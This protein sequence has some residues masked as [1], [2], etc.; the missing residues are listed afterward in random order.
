MM[1]VLGGARYITCIHHLLH[2]I[3]VL[4]LLIAVRPLVVFHHH[5]HHLTHFLH[6]HGIRSRSPVALADPRTP[7]DGDG[8]EADNRTD[9]EESD[10]PCLHLCRCEG[11]DREH[12]QKEDTCEEGDDRQ[13]VETSERNEAEIP[14]GGGHHGFH[15]GIGEGGREKDQ[16][17]DTVNIPIIPLL[18]CSA[19]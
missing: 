10:S 1:L 19:M 15:D 8:E 9:N 13:N 3:A 17:S 7:D 2:H 16:D 14:A 4:S 5:F 6:L 18:R 12:D 11:L